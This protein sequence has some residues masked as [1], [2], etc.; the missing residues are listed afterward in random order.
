[1]RLKKQVEELRSEVFTDAESSMPLRVCMR[2]CTAS[3]SVFSV[4]VLGLGDKGDF[5]IH[6]LCLLDQLES[7]QRA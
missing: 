4:Y 2:V 3:V 6:P 7:T 1:M 5:P